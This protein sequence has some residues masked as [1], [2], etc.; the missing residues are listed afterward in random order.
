MPVSRVFRVRRLIF[1]IA[2]LVCM[3]EG[4]PKK[5][6]KSRTGSQE[7]HITNIS[8]RDDTTLAVRNERGHIFLLGMRFSSLS[9]V[10]MYLYCCHVLS[11]KRAHSSPLQFIIA[12]QLW[13]FFILWRFVIDTHSA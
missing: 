6:K 10:W 8:A 1:A 3:S 13:R 2:C 11:S 4:E 7:V 9:F 5:K 12:L